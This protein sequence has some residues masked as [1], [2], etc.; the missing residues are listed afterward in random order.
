MIRLDENRRA[1]AIEAGWRAYE[2]EIPGHRDAYLRACEGWQ[3][4]AICDDDTPI[5]ALLVKDGVIHL[6]IVPEWRGR[7]ASR[8]VIQELISYGRATTVPPDN[9]RD[10]LR[11]VGFKPQGG[12]Y[13]FSR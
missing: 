11:R 3:L 2:A 6:G 7:W 12:R 5:G 1:D 4:V 10:F 9:R 13:V 8:R